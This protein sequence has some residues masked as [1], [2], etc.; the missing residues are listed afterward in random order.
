MVENIK[1]FKTTASQFAV[2]LPIFKMFMTKHPKIIIKVVTNNKRKREAS[3]SELNNL[4]DLNVLFTGIR[5]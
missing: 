1:G 5:D 2:N 4:N 3:D